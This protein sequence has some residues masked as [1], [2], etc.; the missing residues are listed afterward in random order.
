VVHIGV[1]IDHT[2]PQRLHHKP[3][4][5]L[6]NTQTIQSS[7]VPRPLVTSISAIMI[8]VH[9]AKLST[10]YPCVVILLLIRRLENLLF[11]FLY[12]SYGL[13]P[14]DHCMFLQRSTLDRMSC[15]SVCFP[16]LGMTQYAK[17]PFAFAMVSPYWV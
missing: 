3:Y 7:E 16:L 12:T 2:T 8:V 13:W 4:P 5:K 9:S 10:L 15:F 11:V 1:S 17:A 14:R 6:F